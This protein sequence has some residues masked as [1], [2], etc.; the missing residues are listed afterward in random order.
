MEL[1]RYKINLRDARLLPSSRAATICKER[2]V[3]SS[4]V[5][6]LFF[7]PRLAN[8]RA[9]IFYFPSH[10]QS[11]LRGSTVKETSKIE[12]E[13]MGVKL[14]ACNP[15]PHKIYSLLSNSSAR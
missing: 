4:E 8:R 6:G 2:P 10:V 14:T 13:K 1:G 11:F 12:L 5:M 3:I 7:Y 15:D 9:R